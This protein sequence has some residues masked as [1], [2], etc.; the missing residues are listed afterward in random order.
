MKQSK[1]HRQ[2][3]LDF[4]IFG[5]LVGFWGPAALLLSCLCDAERLEQLRVL[6]GQLDDLLDLSDLLLQAPDHVVR[7]VRHLLHLHQAHQRV[8]LK[9]AGGKKKKKSDL[10]SRK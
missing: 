10:K 8:H 6:D 2:P 9:F 7:R 1:G 5:S 3:W 4:W